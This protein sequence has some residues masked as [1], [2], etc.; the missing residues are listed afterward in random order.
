MRVGM[1]NCLP[2]L[3]AGLVLEDSADLNHSWILFP[4]FLKLNLSG[5][6]TAP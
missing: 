4:S 6:S 1:V 3:A 2:A 5:F